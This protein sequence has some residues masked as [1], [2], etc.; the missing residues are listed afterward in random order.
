[1]S[2]FFISLCFQVI[3][4]S[5]AGACSP[6][7]LGSGYSAWSIFYMTG[8]CFRTDE[9]FIILIDFFFSLSSPYSNKGGGV[10]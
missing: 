5:E 8:L 1:M 9:S 7:L 10:K 4:A 6:Y 2:A 3:I